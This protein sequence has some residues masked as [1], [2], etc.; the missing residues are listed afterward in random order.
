MGT[1]LTTLPEIVDLGLSLKE[2]KFVGEYCNNRF[3][4]TEAVRL[5]KIL[6]ST[7]SDIECRLEGM[8]LSN[9]GDIKKAVQRF[10][11]SIVEPIRD[12]IEATLLQ[13]TVERATYD[14]KDFYDDEGNM[15]PMSELTQLQ[16]SCIDGIEKQSLGKDSIHTKYV[17]ANKDVASKQLRELLKKTEDGVE[18]NTSEEARARVSNVFK[19]A[20][21]DA[22]KEDL[23][24]MKQ[25]PIFEVVD[26]VEESIKKEEQV[27]EIQ[28]NK[29]QVEKHIKK[30]KPL[31]ETCSPNYKGVTMDKRSK[32]YRESINRPPA[33]TKKNG[34]K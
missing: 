13:Q 17:L 31:R 22:V 5:A 19:R 8:K 2:V 9:R 21:Q 25:A 30:E 33:R 20:L 3:N 6:P 16:R 28:K 10:V 4:A 27:E 1:D 29:E 7:A 24:S 14:V 11:Q 32:E 15:K 34:K 26:K 12:S 18:T 23:V